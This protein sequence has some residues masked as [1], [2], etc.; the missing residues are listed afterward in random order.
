MKLLPKI[1]P[2]DVID[3]SEE[4]LLAIKAIFDKEKLQDVVNAMTFFF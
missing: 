2:A 1:R 3:I 4:H